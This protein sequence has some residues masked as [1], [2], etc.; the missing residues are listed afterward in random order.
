[1]KPRLLSVLLTA[2]LSPLAAQT[3]DTLG[4]T[5]SAPS[6]AN[7]GK[8]SL[9]KVD[10][11]VLLTNYEMWL[12]VPGVEN[13]TWF[14]HR[15]H[16]RAGIFTLEWTSTVAVDGT[17]I[18]P[19]WYSTGAIA[20]PLIEGNYY[21]LGVYWPGTLTYFYST[22][23][24]NTPVS[25][26]SWQRAHSITS[27]VPATINVPAGVDIAVYRQ[28]LTTLPLGAVNIVGTGC[29][30]TALVPR[31]VASDM[32]SVGSTCSLDLVDAAPS[33][34]GVYALAIAPTL[35]VPLPLFGCSVWLDL[36]GP[37]VT[38]AVITSAT[39]IANLPLTIPAD[40]SYF[41][42]QLSAQAGVL[43]TAIDM[44][45]ALDLQVN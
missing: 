32:L 5:A 8:A 3:V 41:G 42:L 16:S 40:P 33:S 1:M 24:T 45:A 22:G 27:S 9:F 38:I 15:Y 10:S 34:L 2:L 39:G 25:F 20:M 36:G 17:G 21:I 29:S 11:S 7:R 19:A 23:A 18:G 28:Q 13:L 12:N 4:G 6:G 26:G 14:M 30:S 37:V 44:T 35:P 31:L 43:S